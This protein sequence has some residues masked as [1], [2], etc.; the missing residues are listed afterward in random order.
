MR[1]P[2]HGEVWWF[3]LPENDIIPGE[4]GVY[5][6]QHGRRRDDV[7]SG[8]IISDNY[9]NNRYDMYTIVGMTT[10]GGRTNEPDFDFTQCGYMQHWS[11]MV[12]KEDNP[13]LDVRA[14]IVNGGRIW[15]VPLA[16][17]VAFRGPLVEKDILAAK[18]RLRRIFTGEGI[19]TPHRW[20]DEAPL[21]RGEVLEAIESDA[22]GNERHNWYMVVSA[23]KVDWLRREYGLCTVIRLVSFDAYIDAYHH[24]QVFTSVWVGG[25]G[26]WSHQIAVCSRIYT[27][28][29]DTDGR[30]MRRVGM[31]YERAEREK[32]YETVLNT[33]LDLE[34]AE[35]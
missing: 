11:V 30:D 12:R 19:F 18:T 6:D 7:I 33:Y 3:R 31:V 14:S 32:I 1:R 13:W 4:M 35:T 23:P 8:L 26:E 2:Q 22:S 15:T 29:Y 16:W 17:A 28:R 34:S 24:D 5:L 9:F 20:T 10:L 25:L 27:Y 21:A